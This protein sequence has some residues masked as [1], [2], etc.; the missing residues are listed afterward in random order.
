MPA[1]PSTPF[2]ARQT[3][4]LLKGAVFDVAVDIC[5]GSSTYRQHA[6]V[7]LSENNYRQFFIHS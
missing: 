1:F 2:Y 6:S 7:E 3:G 4:A 5:K